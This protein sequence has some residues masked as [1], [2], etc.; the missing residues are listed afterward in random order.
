MTETFM[1]DY[2]TDEELEALQL[3]GLKWTCD[4]VYAGSPFYRQK[5]DEA[6]VEP[7]DVK[8]L[9]DL[10]RLPFVDAYD[11]REQYPFPLLSINDL[12]GLG[13]TNALQASKSFFDVVWAN[14]NIAELKNF[15]VITA[16]STEPAFI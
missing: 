7:E 8:T 5:L 9:E 1:P 16:F 15:K 13:Y 12:P 10:R 3:A 4:H 14:Q 11:V 2:K 6:G